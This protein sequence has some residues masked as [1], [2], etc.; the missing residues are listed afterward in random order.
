MAFVGRNEKKEAGI[1][2]SYVAMETTAKERA[3]DTSAGR[4]MCFWQ[5]WT[6]IS[7]K[8]HTRRCFLFFCN[9]GLQKKYSHPYSIFCHFITIIFMC[10]IGIFLCLIDLHKLWLNCHVEGNSFFIYFLGIVHIH[11]PCLPEP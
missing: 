5:R 2:E 9:E 6:N 4:D 8:Q 1:Q 10:Y 11:R 7:V 3:G